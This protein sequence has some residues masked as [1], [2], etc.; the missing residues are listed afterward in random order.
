VVAYGWQ[1]SQYIASS[2]D[3]ERKMI[4]YLRVLYTLFFGVT[5][6]VYLFIASSRTDG[7]VMWATAGI[8]LIGLGLIVGVAL[9]K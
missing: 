3:K 2:K 7:V 5:G 4:E 1:Y 8:A 6:A 9:K